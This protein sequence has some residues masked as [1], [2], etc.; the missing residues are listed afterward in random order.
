VG[1][2]VHGAWTDA[3]AVDVEV[4]NGLRAPME[5]S[6]GQFRV[7][8]DGGPTVSLYSSDRDAGPVGPGATTTLRILFLA[9]PPDQGLSLEFDD[10][11]A[12]RPVRLGRLGV[13]GPES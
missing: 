3:V 12:S 13:V 11:G 8:V 4:H 10:T 1:S 2:A 5:L 9:P 7:R 6:P